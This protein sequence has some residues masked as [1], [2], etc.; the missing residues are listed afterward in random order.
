MID[1]AGLGTPIHVEAGRVLTVQGR[2]GREFFLISSGTATCHA[3]GDTVAELGPGDF[4]GELSLLAHTPRAATV[5][6]DSDMELVVFSAQ[7]F[8]RLLH[9]SPAFAAR[10][11][12]RLADRVHALEAA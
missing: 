10:M 5:I 6:A 2:R 12:G 11:V 7:E 4:F 9:D 1:V 8:D 3:D